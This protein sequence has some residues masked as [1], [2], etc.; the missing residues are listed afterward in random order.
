MLEPKDVGIA[1]R[2]QRGKGG[3][4]FRASKYLRN[5]I[6]SRFET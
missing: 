2:V 3:V 5:D 6:M 1:G 4:F